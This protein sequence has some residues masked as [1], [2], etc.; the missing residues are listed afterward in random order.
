MLSDVIR[1]NSICCVDIVILNQTTGRFLT[2]TGSCENP[3]SPEIIKPSFRDRRSND[4]STKDVGYLVMN[5]R[6][7]NRDILSQKID[8]RKQNTDSFLEPS[9]LKPAP[10]RS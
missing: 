4:Y 3:P 6:N 1:I 10:A 2:K 5:N 7:M 8:N 9:Q